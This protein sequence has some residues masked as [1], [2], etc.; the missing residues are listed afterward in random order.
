MAENKGDINRKA[1][2]EGIEI[3]QF[4]ERVTGSNY[5][6]Y[7]RALDR[8]I[9]TDADGLFS[10]GWRNVDVGFAGYLPPSHQNI[11][12]LLNLLVK[13]VGSIESAI[14]RYGEGKEKEKLAAWVIL[15]IGKIHPRVEGNGRLAEAAAEQLVPQKMILGTPFDG[16]DAVERLS[17][18]DTM[19]KVSALNG[20]PIPPLLI[21]LHENFGSHDREELNRTMAGFYRWNGKD[22]VTEV[23]KQEIDQMS[24][25]SEGNLTAPD[26]SSNKALMGMSV[27]IDEAP[28]RPLR[29]NPK[30]QRSNPISR[31]WKKIF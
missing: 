30:A 17:I 24:V 29:P 11:D 25:D 18:E 3:G 8:R 6:G 5:S 10:E 12:E 19:N 16:W 21:V 1:L 4:R 20:Q 26:I 14:P 9:F 23:L 7:I 2:R 22:W 31:I 27:F 15:M 13:K 28:E